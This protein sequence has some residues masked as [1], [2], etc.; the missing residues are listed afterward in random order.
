MTRVEYNVTEDYYGRY[1]EWKGWGEDQ[2]MLLGDAERAYFDAEFSGIAVKGQK[3]LEVGFGSG[4]LLGW[5]RGNGAELYGTELSP[6]GIAS[7]KR[8]GVVV[9][10][11]DLSQTTGMDGQFGVVAAF[12]VLEH[13]THQETNALLDRAATLLRPGGVFIARFPNGAS[14]LGRLH[15]HADITHV[16]TM[17]AE[18]IVQLMIGKPFEVQRAGDIAVA[19]H[20]GVA[21]RLGKK[22]RSLLR[23]TFETGICAL[24]GLKGPPLYGHRMPFGP[25]LIIVLRRL[26]DG[27]DAA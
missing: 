5:L 7:A 8:Q 4:A 24:Y 10:D 9:L 15:Q 14:P 1:D 25:N 18:K 13:L 12:D 17:T 22:I 3:V 27:T 23:R 21:S 11:T 16:T 2:F 20:G 19:L 26:P 6:Q